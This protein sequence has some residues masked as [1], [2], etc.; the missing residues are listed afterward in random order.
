MAPF[1]FSLKRHH[2]LVESILLQF[3]QDIISHSQ[4][5]QPL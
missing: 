1:Q 2:L 5:I 3:K 4:E